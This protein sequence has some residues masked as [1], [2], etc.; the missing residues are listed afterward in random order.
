MGTD[1][2]N[3]YEGLQIL[4]YQRKVGSLLYATTMT[5]PD[6][7]RTANKLSEFLINPSAKNHE[8]ADKAISY[9]YGTKSLAIQ[10]SGNEDSILY[11]SDAAY[12]DHD[13]RKSTEG[14][15]FK[16]FGGAVEAGGLRSKR[17]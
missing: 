11:A 15:L 4:L 5:R 13:D 8:A 9:L 6:V 14:F 1:A 17:R 12:A 10:Y 16:L 3:K 7:A 2:L